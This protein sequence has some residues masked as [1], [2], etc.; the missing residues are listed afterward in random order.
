MKAGGRSVPPWLSGRHTGLYSD[1]PPAVRWRGAW[2]AAPLRQDCNTE[3]SSTC[4]HTRGHISA[5]RR[6]KRYHRGEAGTGMTRKRGE[7]GAG[8]NYEID[9][10]RQTCSERRR[11]RERERGRERQLWTDLKATERQR[12]KEKHTTPFCLLHQKAFSSKCQSGWISGLPVLLCRALVVWIGVLKPW[13]AGVMLSFTSD[14]A[15]CYKEVNDREAERQTGIW[16]HAH[17]GWRQ[18]LCSR[19]YDLSPQISVCLMRTDISLRC[20][21]TVQSFQREVNRSCPTRCWVSRASIYFWACSP[22][23]GNWIPSR[24]KRYYTAARVQIDCAWMTV[25]P[26]QRKK[27]FFIHALVAF[28][29]LLFPLNTFASL[30]FSS[31]YLPPTSLAL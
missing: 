17:V 4:T 3:I 28:I 22:L 21:T 30:F 25:Q 13:L 19:D 15:V 8:W 23:K 1:N 26:I 14:E 11:K 16:R 7:G 12:K 5:L 6:H 2:T 29:R 31:L 18:R 9:K 10:Q 20:F 24:I 27:F